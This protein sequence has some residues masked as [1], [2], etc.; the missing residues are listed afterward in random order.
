MSRLRQ[1]HFDI[2]DAIAADVVFDEMPVVTELT[3]DTTAEA[4]LVNQMTNLIAVLNGNGPKIGAGVIVLQPVLR[5]E[6]QNIPGPRLKVRHTIQVLELPI[7][8]RGDAG[9]GVTGTELV[10]RLLRLF[11]HWMP[12]GTTCLV[13]EKTAT[14][15]LPREYIE[16]GYEGYEVHFEHAWSLD[17]LT[18][19]APVTITVAATVTLVTATSGA[20]IYYT[21]DGEL[22]TPANG[23]LYSAPFT[24]PASGTLIRAAAVKSDYRLSNVSEK[25][26]A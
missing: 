16:A 19:V 18:P 20:A 2:A 15:P 13:A 8:N 12:D 10:E 25:E 17:V 11:Q 24:A 21:T 4:A 14:S 7:Y 1:I 22:P 3:R 26:V 23:T 9:F 5:V 6:E